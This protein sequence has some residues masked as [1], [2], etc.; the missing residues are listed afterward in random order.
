[1]PSQQASQGTAAPR[2]A[3]RPAGRV[4]NFSP[5]PAMLPD[6][7]MARV[8]E[9]FLNYAGLGASVIEISHR[10]KQIVAITEEAAAL[11]R[12]LVRLPENYS[13]LFMHGG[14]RMQFS[15]VRARRPTLKRAFSPPRPSRTPLLTAK[16]KPSPAAAAKSLYAS[17]SSRER[18]SRPILRT[19]TSPP[20]TRPTGRAGTNFPRRA[21]FRWWET[22]L[23]KSFRGSWIIRASESFTRGCRKIWDRP[24]PR[25]SLSART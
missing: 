22:R 2:T 9:E 11:F 24:G 23:R 10:S 17:P 18:A 13:V 1:M 19:F 25:L 14:G 7:I 3:A 6:E 5:G 4:F 16:L 20:T 8:Q 21:K 12:E 15:A